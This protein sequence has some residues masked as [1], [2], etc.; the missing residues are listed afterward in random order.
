[1]R[2]GNP[3]M[4]GN[5]WLAG[6][7]PAFRLALASS[8]LAPDDWRERQEA[9]IRAICSAGPDWSEYL[10][11][12]DRHRTPAISWAVLKR[13]RGLEIPV[14]FADDLQKRSDACRMQALRHFQVLITILKSLDQAGIPAMPLKGP[15]LSLEIYGDVGLRQSKDLDI[16]VLFKDLSRAEKCLME[17]G[18]SL[19]TKDASLSLSQR[20]F[21]VLHGHHVTY[22]HPG[23]HCQLELHWRASWDTPEMTDRRWD[24]AITSQ[25][26]GCPYRAMNPVDLVLYLCNHGSAHAWFRAK[27]LGDLA[28]MT[29]A[30]K[31][32]W[33][34]V[35]EEAHTANQERPV[36]TCLS[37]LNGTCGI[38]LPDAAARQVHRFPRRL[39]RKSLRELKCDVEAHQRGNF[40]RI[41][42][43]IR[44][45][46]Y[47]RQLWPYRPMRQN[48]MEFAISP[49]DFDE[50][51]LPDRLFWLYVP[52]RP[53]LWVWR[54]IR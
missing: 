40:A 15:L 21:L 34:A 37:L 26:N 22:L 2:Q 11:L 18:W 13:V 30:A 42:A 44:S 29:M 48:L 36:L 1:M 10:R 43:Q 16:A 19:S 6:R 31:V 49:L 28:R 7:S 46:G 38:P 35:M 3:A 50:L 23:R 5:D 54:H 27:W 14:K 17:T 25:W 20:E 45:I 4:R 47:L 41:L 9:S 8:V 52:L 51:R 12:V 24:R 32:D 39:I 53:V 33:K